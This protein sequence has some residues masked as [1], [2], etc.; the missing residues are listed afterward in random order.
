M[1]TVRLKIAYPSKYFK[2][3]YFVVHEKWQISGCSNRKEYS[4]GPKQLREGKIMQ[5]LIV[6]M[7][8]ATGAILGVRLLQ[9]LKNCDVE[10]HLILSKWALRTFEHDTPILSKRCALWRALIT[11]PQIWLRKSHQAHLSLRACWRFHAPCA[12]LAVSRRDMVST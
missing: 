3:C 11:I 1:T 12:C 9:A 10:S 8:A 2:I 5:R 7:T 4:R 6:G